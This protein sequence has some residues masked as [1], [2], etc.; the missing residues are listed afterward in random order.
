MRHLALALVWALAVV[1]CASTTGGSSAAP[2]ATPSPSPSVTVSGEAEG[3]LIDIGGRGLY[4]E[5]MGTGSP[6]V[7]LEAGMTGDHRT[8]EQVQPA[9]AAS[10]R[11]CA[12][13]RANIAPSDPAP[14]P[15]SAEDAVDDL[16]TLLDAADIEGPY[17]LV[18]FSIGGLISQLYAATYPDEIAGLVLVESSHPR[19][20]EQ[21]E[22]HLTPDQIAEDRAATADNPEGFDP[23]ASFEEVQAAGDLPQVPLVVVTA[24]I[25]EGWP[26]GWDAAVFDR[27]RA[28]QQA[29]LAT[30]VSGGRQVVAERSTHH[31][32]SQQPEV[33]VDVVESVLEEAG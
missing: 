25:S 21:F 12:Y 26:P 27:L 32:P 30:L 29:E 15:R 7:I 20:A 2:A 24:G 8:W 13:D 18:G 31:V 28:E 17:V 16:H 19:E 33:I 6:T 4:L 22:A 23:F 5:C 9:L 14:T 11:V 1:G 3:R 10:T